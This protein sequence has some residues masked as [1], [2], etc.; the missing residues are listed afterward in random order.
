MFQMNLKLFTYNVFHARIFS[1]LGCPNS[2]RSASCCGRGFSWICSSTT[3]FLLG[4]AGL[5][6][7]LLFSWLATLFAVMAL[8]FDLGW[9]NDSVGCTNCHMA[10]L[11]CLAWKHFYNNLWFVWRKYLPLTWKRHRVKDISNA[12][13]IPTSLALDAEVKKLAIWNY[14]IK[15]FIFVIEHWGFCCKFCLKKWPCH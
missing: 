12:A 14:G 15:D 3:Y 9:F 2:S 13:S 7:R 4:R 1:P 8:G 5:L 6:G 10:H 11:P